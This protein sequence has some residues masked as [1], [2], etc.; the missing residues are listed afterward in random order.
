MQNY[1]PLDVQW[2][3]QLLN[4]ILS[5]LTNEANRFGDLT[6]HGEVIKYPPIRVTEVNR[7]IDIT[8]E[9]ELT[10]EELEL[11]QPH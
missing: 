10:V 8:P 7:G 4:F 11:E 3:F 5:S 9:K 6:D 1:R 2:L